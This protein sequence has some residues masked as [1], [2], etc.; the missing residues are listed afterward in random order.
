MF[1]IQIKNSHFSK[2]EVSESGDVVLKYKSPNIIV[3]HDNNIVNYHKYNKQQQIIPQPI[4]PIPHGSSS[5]AY[6]S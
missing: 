5:P 4:T 3:P 6:Q 2:P 1:E